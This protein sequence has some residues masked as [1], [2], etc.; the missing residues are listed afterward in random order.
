MTTFDEAYTVLRK[1]STLLVRTEESQLEVWE[2]NNCLMTV[3]D[4][5]KQEFHAKK[6]K[7]DPEKYD[8]GRTE[9][10]EQSGKVWDYCHNQCFQP[11]RHVKPFRSRH[12]VRN[13]G[14]RFPLCDECW[15]KD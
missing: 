3:V 4:L 2:T 9:L 14:E 8:A 6:R 1:N 10:L 7:D 15:G 13:A 11:C 12:E 5:R